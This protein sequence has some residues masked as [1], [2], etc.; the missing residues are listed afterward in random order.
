MEEVGHIP[1]L[2]DATL[3]LLKPQPGNVIVDGTLGRAGHAAEL[4]RSIL[5]GGTLVG[6]DLDVRNLSF[7]RDRLAAKHPGL[8]CTLFHANYVEIPQQLVELGIA[9]DVVLIDLG[10]SSNQMNDPT[11]GFSFRDDGK[12][13]MRLNT[14]ADT[15]TA[16]DLLANMSEEQLADLIYQLG[17][18]PFARRIARTIVADRKRIPVETTH[19]LAELVRKAYGSRAHKSRMHPATR[20]FMALR[21]AVNS[22][23]DALRLVLESISKEA[24]AD[25]R[26]WLA[27]GARVGMIS[28]HSLE[29][30]MVKQAFRQ[31]A[32]AGHATRLTRKPIVADDGE[33]HQNPRARSAKLRAIQLD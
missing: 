2:L 24:R 5:P 12:L 33:I 29:D 17:E 32:D 27:A 6:F 13:D 31:L 15:P 16:A 30:R 25:A 8:M 9:A 19:Q 22:E 23:L 14:S 20:T 10:F 21:I 26:T 1:V 3:D 7:S 11:R 18:D 4:A 28:F